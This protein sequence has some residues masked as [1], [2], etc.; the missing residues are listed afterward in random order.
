M[1][2]TPDAL[3]DYFQGMKCHQNISE[4]DGL[5]LDM[6][7][8]IRWQGKEYRRKNDKIIIGNVEFTRISYFFY[9]DR[10][11]GI[12]VD[13]INKDNFNEVIRIFY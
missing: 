13:I 6:V 1:F 11:Y 4:T 7:R 12:A 10:F 9:D 8:G 2:S 5:I 3:A